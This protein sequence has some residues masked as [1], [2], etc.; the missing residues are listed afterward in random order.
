MNKTVYNHLQIHLHRLST[1]FLKIITADTFTIF[2]IS[3]QKYISVQVV[4]S[5]IK[6]SELVNRLAGTGNDRRAG[7]R[8]AG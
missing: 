6:S 2:S 7:I 3:L 8:L 4:F 1:F 5:T